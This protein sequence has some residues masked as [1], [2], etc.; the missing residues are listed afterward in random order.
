MR[1]PGL[2]K[3]AYTGWE[4]ERTSRTCKKFRYERSSGGYGVAIRAHPRRPQLQL[5]DTNPRA[6][7]RCCVYY[8]Y[9][10]NPNLYFLQNP[11][12]LYRHVSAR[13][14]THQKPGISPRVAVWACKSRKR[15]LTSSSRYFTASRMAE[16]SPVRRPR[17]SRVPVSGID[18]DPLI[19]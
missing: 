3:A 7:M 19:A 10:S 5:P 14:H 16:V 15:N 12:P 2:E 8:P 13:W 18:F 6:T 17:Q 11:F 1:G 4:A 9:S